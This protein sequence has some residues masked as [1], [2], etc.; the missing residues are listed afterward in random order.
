MTMDREAEPLALLAVREN[1][2]VP[3]D[4]GAPEMSPPGEPFKPPGNPEKEKED[5][6]LA[7][8]CHEKT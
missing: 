4:E 6:P 1:Q 8:A 5:A 2:E 7:E 3:G